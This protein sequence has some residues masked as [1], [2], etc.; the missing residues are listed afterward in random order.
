MQAIAQPYLLTADEGTPLWFLGTLTLVKA[1]G[2]QTGGTFGLIE[3]RIPAGF[4]SPYHLHHREDEAFYVTEGELAVIVDGKWSAAPA[5][6]FVYGPREVPHGFKAVGER[7]AKLL[8]LNTPAGFEHFV[9]EMSEPAATFTYPTPAAPDMAKLMA[10]AA[11][12][13]VD[14]LGP[15]PE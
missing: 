11:Q 5:G 2:E 3:N 15:L 12:Y 6:T 4:S 13:G 9:I 1:T 8:L 10:V 7:S 14:I